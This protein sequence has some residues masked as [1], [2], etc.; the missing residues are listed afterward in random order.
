MCFFSLS[1][2]PQKKFCPVWLTVLFITSARGLHGQFSSDMTNTN[3]PNP[4]LIESLHPVERKFLISFKV[5]LSPLKHGKGRDSPLLFFAVEVAFFTSAC[6]CLLPSPITL[7]SFPHL[8][9][10]AL[11]GGGALRHHHQAAASLWFLNRN[12]TSGGENYNHTSKYL[13]HQRS[14][15]LELNKQDI[16]FCLK[17]VFW[18]QQKK[19]EKENWR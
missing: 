4:A 16:L 9:W 12:Q 3:T 19:K 18:Y 8:H 1:T 6:S 10:P 15:V 13:S 7:C 11:P 14:R 2:P 5:T 17:A